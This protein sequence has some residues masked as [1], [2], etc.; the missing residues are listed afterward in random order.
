MT[1]DRTV[2]GQV[3]ISKGLSAGEKVAIDGLLRL[4][5][6]A[7]VQIVADAKKPGDAS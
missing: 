5:D 4:T 7:R 2:A 3:V 6:G 1:V